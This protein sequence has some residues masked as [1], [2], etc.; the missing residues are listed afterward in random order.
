M[1]VQSE[2]DDYVLD[3]RNDGILVCNVPCWNICL[4]LL[5]FV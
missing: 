3:I 5:K 2:H 4:V 1:A